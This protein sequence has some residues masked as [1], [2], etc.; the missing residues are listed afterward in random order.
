MVSDGPVA[1]L[2]LPVEYAAADERLLDSV[3]LMPSGA[4]GFSARSGRRPGGGLA[5]TFSTLTATV[6]PG[7]GVIYDPTFA[8]GGPWRFV[9]PV[10]R[11]VTLAARPGAGL[12]RKDLIIAR[13][14]DSDSGAGTAKELKIEAV[15]GTASAT[16]SKPSLPPLSLELGVADVA[17]SGPVSFVANTARTV[18]AGG[19]LPVAST[20]ERN[21]LPAPHAGLV[22]FNEQTKRLEVFDGTAWQLTGNQYAFPEG[23]R[24]GA[25]YNPAIHRIIE[26]RRT[27]V[28]VPNSS[29]NINIFN[30]DT[31]FAGIASFQMTIGFDGGNARFVAGE[32]SGTLLYANIRNSNGNIV[33]SGNHRI[34]VSVTG[35]AT[36]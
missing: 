19:I 13:I 5:V 9:L 24:W 2:N 17:P 18:A 1:R 30:L 20:T 34:E 32:T 29:G 12:V 6:A 33:T 35:W 10:S 7:A 4:G 36:V 25:V 14:Y 21:D 28:A 31:V 23:P 11:S 27:I 26:Y 15:T 3:L 22:V 16:P 8:A